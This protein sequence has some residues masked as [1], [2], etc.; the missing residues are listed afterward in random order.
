MTNTIKFTEA[1][2]NHLKTVLREDVEKRMKSIRD[3]HNASYYDN[4]NLARRIERY[5]FSLNLLN[6]V[7][8]GS[9]PPEA[10][11]EQ[12]PEPTPPTNDMFR[13]D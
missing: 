13:I 3:A 2:I 7:I 1:E 11:G 9:Q 5:N 12:V 4:Q 8:E 6:R 10:L